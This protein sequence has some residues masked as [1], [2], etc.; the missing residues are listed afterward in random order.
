MLTVTLLPK[1]GEPPVKGASTRSESAE[2]AG[3]VTGEGFTPDSGERGA[4]PAAGSR[5]RG[6][7]RG[8]E[9]AEHEGEPAREEAFQ[10]DRVRQG[11]AQALVCASH[12][13]F[14]EPQAE[15]PH[16]QVDL[17]PSGR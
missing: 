14:Q 16:A 11:Q 8:E 17:R 13:G 4:P 3:P 2:P 1:P 15:A 9:H 6:G 7:A 12:P 10:A 5:K